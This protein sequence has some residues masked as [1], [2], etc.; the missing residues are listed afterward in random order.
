MSSLDDLRALAVRATEAAGEV[1]RQAMGTAVAADVKGHGDYVTAVDREAER[2]AVA[3]LAAGSP[4]IAILAEESS[5]AAVRPGSGR[6]WAVDPLDGTTN[7]VRGYPVVGVSV[8]LLEDGVAVAGAVCAPLLGESWSAARG[9][10]AWDGRGR[11]L[12]VRTPAGA[13]VA[14][15]GFPFR[16][17]DNRSRYLAVLEGA[18]SEMEDLR[19]AGAASLD[20]AYAAAGVFD[21]FF[22]LGLSVWD[23]AGGA[24]LVTEA[25]GV[26]TD[27]DGDPDGVWRS[28]DVIA[29]APEWH[30]R[31]LEVVRAAR[32]PSPVAT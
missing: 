32:R 31:M 21:G 6:V 20:L 1:V 9:L 26:V 3:V 27:W 30:E 16:K 18:L 29:G 11:R 4:G 2:A 23:I 12:S 22:E 19:R 8:G 7:F 25:G 15:T 28:G 13:G 24:V 14:S 17:P 5:D 10:G